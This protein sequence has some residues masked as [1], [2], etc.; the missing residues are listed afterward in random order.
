VD[1]RRPHIPI[2]NPIRRWV[3]LFLAAAVA[4]SVAL[5]SFTIAQPTCLEWLLKQKMLANYSTMLGLF[6]SL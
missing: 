4:S 6:S 2:G 5:G 1:S 3:A